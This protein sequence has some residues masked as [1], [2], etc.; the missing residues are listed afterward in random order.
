M[1]TQGSVAPGFEKVA[2]AFAASFEEG[3]ELGASFAA[4]VDGETVVELWGG[5]ADRNKARLWDRDTLTPVYSTTKGI[6]AL[7]VARLVDRG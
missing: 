4:I 1:F 6:A 7:V 5:Y 3:L 2:E